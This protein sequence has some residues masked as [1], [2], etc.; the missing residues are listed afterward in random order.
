MLNQK[1][2][3]I[4]EFSLK[5]IYKHNKENDLWIIINNE[6]Y[7]VTNFIKWHPGGKKIFLCKSQ[8]FCENVFKK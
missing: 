2:N 1:K 6:V 5:E 7:D 8:R 4:K 3:N